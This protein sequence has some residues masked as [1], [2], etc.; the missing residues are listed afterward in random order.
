MENHDLTISL[1]PR[2]SYR[3]NVLSMTG[4]LASLYL[5]ADAGFRKDKV[6]VVWCAEKA[7]D[8]RER[9]HLG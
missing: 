4:A 9:V 6:A 3:Q 8:E 7:L 5:V 2:G 1:T